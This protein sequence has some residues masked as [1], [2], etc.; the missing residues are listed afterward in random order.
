MSD[1]LDAALV[2]ELRRWLD[3]ARFADGR[4]TAGRDARLVKHNEQVGR[5]DADGAEMG[6]RVS[7]ALRRNRLFAAAARP[8]TIRPPIFSRYVPGMEYGTHMD[9]ALMGGMRTDLSLTVFL[10]DP[11]SYDGG[12]LV[13]ESSAGEQEVKLPAGCGVLYPTGALH[14]VAP[15]TRGERLAAVTWVRSLVRDPGARE[16][17]FDLENARHL[18]KERLGQTPE[19]LLLSKVQGNL[20]RR[21]VE[22]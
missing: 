1:L 16:I 20:L 12:E 9:D 18:L 8:H 15:V 21:W 4:A 7:E 10:S 11:G 2:A 13:I 17:L 5:D 19:M 6:E 14:R 3:G 22:D